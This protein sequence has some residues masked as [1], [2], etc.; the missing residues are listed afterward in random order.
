MNT[1]MKFIRIQMKTNENTI[2]RLLKTM[3][4]HRK[5]PVELFT[6]KT[7]I[8]KNKSPNE[9]MGHEGFNPKNVGSLMIH[10]GVGFVYKNIVEFY[11]KL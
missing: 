6:K 3:K 4:C 5:N 11:N 1:H 9:L 7:M 2:G 8:I 10:L